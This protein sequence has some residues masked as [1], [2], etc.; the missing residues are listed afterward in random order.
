MDKLQFQKK[1][2][3]WAVITGASSGIGKSYAKLLASYGLNLV[4]AARR[5]SLLQSLAQELCDSHS[6]DVKICVVDLAEEQA[7]KQIEQACEGL[8]VGLLIS[9]AGFGFK[10]EF[11]D[12]EDQHLADMVA[13]NC[14]AGMYL[15]KHFIPQFK[16]KQRGGIIFTG[17]V[18]GELAFPYSASYAASKAFIHS[19]GTALWSELKPYNIDVLVLSPGSTDT[20]APIKQ[21]ISRDQLV[22]LMSPDAVAEQAL[23]RINKG[24]MFIPGRMNRMVFPLMARLSKGLATKLMGKGMLQA[25][26]NSQK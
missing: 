12:Q 15:A 11:V 6:V 14:L 25:I 20:E 5:E 9:N 2:G 3:D 1:Y 21:G 17:S 26:E 22:G 19:L 4:L 7:C 18:E 10:G 13:T 24:P 16:E 8:D 23:V